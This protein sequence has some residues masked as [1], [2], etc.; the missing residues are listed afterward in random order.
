MGRGL[1]CTCLGRSQQKGAW[2]IVF[3]AIRELLGQKE[4][5]GMEVQL[6]FPTLNWGEQQYK[7][8]GVVT[9]RDLAGISSSGGLGNGVAREKRCMP[10]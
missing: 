8:F 4:F 10:S 7:L 9:N 6:P 2:F 3:L 5:P 1:F